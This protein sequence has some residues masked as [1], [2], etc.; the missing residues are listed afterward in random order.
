[1]TAG[2]RGDLL[3]VFQANNCRG[4]LEQVL[5]LFMFDPSSLLFSL[6]VVKGTMALI[7]LLFRVTR[8]RANGLP[9]MTGAMALGAVSTMLCRRDLISKTWVGG[10]LF[11]VYYLVFLAGL[12]WLS[13][14][15]IGKVWNLESLSG[16]LIYG[17]PI[18]ELLFAVM[19]GAYWSGVYE[20]FT[21][22][23]VTD[24]H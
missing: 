11:L 2:R 20:H 18:E 22:R 13:P 17:M 5:T 21:W 1:M 24:I 19:F 15:Y 4:P 14:G 12:E 6:F 9:E 7:L 3:R 16:I 10:V 23:R 8:F